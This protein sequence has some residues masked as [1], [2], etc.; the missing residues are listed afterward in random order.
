[1]NERVGTIGSNAGCFVRVDSKWNKWSNKDCFVGQVS[2]GKEWQ[3]T[4][5][6]NVTEEKMDEI[7]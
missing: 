6:R 3:N 2:N 1:M 4:G 7:K 5:T